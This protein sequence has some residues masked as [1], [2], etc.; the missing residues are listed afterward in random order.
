MRSIL[1][2]LANSHVERYFVGWVLACPREG[3]F[4]LRNRS[5]HPTTG[6]PN[7]PHHPKPNKT[8]P[9]FNS[10]TASLLNAP[11]GCLN[12]GRTRCDIYVALYSFHSLYSGGT[13]SDREILHK[14][15][16][17]L[18]GYNFCNRHA[19]QYPDHTPKFGRGNARKR[20]KNQLFLSNHFSTREERGLI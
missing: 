10:P 4:D 7:D 20:A 6:R 3:I 9:V 8:M 19:T 13:R 17:C 12:T 2:L 14:L 16:M 18:R 15:I 11:T 1:M 5:T